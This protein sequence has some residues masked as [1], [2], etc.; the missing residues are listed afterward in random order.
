MVYQYHKKGAN[1]SNCLSVGFIYSKMSKE[2]ELNSIL[3]LISNKLWKLSS[4]KY[5]EDSDGNKWTE[6]DTNVTN[7][8]VSDAYFNKFFGVCTF[9]KPVEEN[10][11]ISFELTYEELSKEDFGFLIQIDASQVYEFGNA[12]SL[13]RAELGI[14]ELAEC[15]YKVSKY[16]YIF[17][18]DEAEIEYT[19]EQMK[20]ETDF[21]YSIL[22][23]P[24]DEDTVEIKLAPWALDGLTSR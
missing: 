4:L 21:K 5:S 14:I 2:K 6:L 3:K 16:S 18:D 15:L 19:A 23:F 9:C 12:E 10:K 1:M 24:K 8:D 11:K 7:F 22:I 17:S 20:F 13:K